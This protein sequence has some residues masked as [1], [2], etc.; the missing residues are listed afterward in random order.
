MANHESQC[1]NLDSRDSE[2]QS[3]QLKNWKQLICN[4]YVLRNL[5]ALIMPKYGT[6]SETEGLNFAIYAGQSYH[7]A[8]TPGGVFPIVELPP[9]N[10]YFIRGMIRWRDL[11]TTNSMSQIAQT[12][13]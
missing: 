13:T 10:Q 7:Y 8:D 11:P 2:N 9:S 6:I 4:G 3:R 5:A 12:A 1:W